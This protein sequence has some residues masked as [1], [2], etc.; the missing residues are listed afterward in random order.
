MSDRRLHLIADYGSAGAWDP[1]GNPLDPP[2]LPLS[3]KLRTRLTR[4]CARFEIFDTEIVSRDE[5][6]KFCVDGRQ[7]FTGNVRLALALGKLPA[8]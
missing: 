1:N 4:W 2:T 3:A 5:P 6:F 7:A 8:A